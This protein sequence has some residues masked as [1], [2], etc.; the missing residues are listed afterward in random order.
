M[1]QLKEKTHKE[2]AVMIETLKSKIEEKR[3]HL[4][5]FVEEHKTLKASLKDIEDDHKRKKYQY[6][7][8][9]S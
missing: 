1:E 9:T 7:Q 2:I 4:K 3:E 5:P 6:E 8:V